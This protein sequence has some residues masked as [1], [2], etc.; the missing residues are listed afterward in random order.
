VSTLGQHPLK[1]LHVTHG[2]YPESS[3]G[4][5]AYVRDLLRHQRAAGLE[6]LLLTGSIEPW[7]ECG[8]EALS[9]DGLRVLRLHRDDHFFDHYAKAWHPGVERLF[10]EVVQRESPDVVHVHQW[11][12][13]TSNLV[14]IAE[15]L[16]VPAVVT[17][18]DLY[19]SCPRCFRVRRD[20]E[21]CFR[22]LSVASCLDCV[23]RFGHEDDAEVAEGIALHHDQ[24]GAELARARAVLASTATTADLICASMGF[25]RERMEILP[26]AYERRWPAGAPPPAPLPEAG[27]AFRFGYWGNLT[28]RKGAQVLLRAL[29]ILLERGAARPV[30]LVLFGHIDARELERELRALAD[31]LPVRFPGRYSYA[32]LAAAGLHMAVFPMVC[33]ETFGLVLDECFEL[34]LPAIVTAIGAMPERAGAAALVVP[35]RDPQ[36]LALAMGRAVAEPAICERLRAAIPALPP[37]LAAHAAALQAIYERARGSA[38]RLAPRVDPLRRAAFVLRQRESALRRAGPA[39]GPH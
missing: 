26:L 23:P 3:G 33:F 31:G 19:T 37:P 36:A 29:R 8:I 5:E 38:P 30:E 6:V 14:E 1:I 2:Y 28:R 4:V 39:D 22:P 18:H 24:Y 13:L 11:I 16:G 15:D 20:D 25:A 7:P 10:R 27:A 12:R 9:S 21:A 32:E 17:L 34:R 35:P